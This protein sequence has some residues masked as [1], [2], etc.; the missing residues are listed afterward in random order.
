MNA[1]FS[2]C[3]NCG[4]GV[5]YSRDVEN[6]DLY[7]KIGWIFAIATLLFLIVM[8]VYF[9]QIFYDLGDWLLEQL[10]SID[11]AT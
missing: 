4:G 11:E 1:G 10:N 6:S 5:S 8:S 3:V 2:R 7:R 9:P